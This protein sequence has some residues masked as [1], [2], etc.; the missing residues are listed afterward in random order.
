MAAELHLE[1]MPAPMQRVFEALAPLVI[2]EGFYLAGDTAVAPTPLLDKRRKVVYN[3]TV[4]LRR[5]TAMMAMRRASAF[6][7]APRLLRHATVSWGD[8]SMRCSLE[9][10]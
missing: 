10:L 6:I 7:T 1:V 8:I 2:T 9:A 3:S 4:I 5:A